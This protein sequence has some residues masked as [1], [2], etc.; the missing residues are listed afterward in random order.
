MDNRLN[1]LVSL[2]VPVFNVAPYLER[3][4]E[5]ICHQTHKDIE[6]ILVDDGSNDGSSE[7]CDHMARRDNRIR[8]IHQVN[9]GLSA[10]RNVG[11]EYAT[12]EFLSFVDSDDWILPHFV[13]TMLDI[14]TTSGCKLVMCENQRVKGKELFVSNKGTYKIFTQDEVIPRFLKGEWVSAWGKLYQRSLFDGIRFPIGRNNEDYAILIYIFEQCPQ[15]AYTADPLYC[16]IIRY[17]SITN[18]SLNEHSFDEYLNGQ[19]VWAYCL[20]RFPK[21][22]SLALFNLTASIIK[23]TGLCVLNAVFLN[24]YDDMRNFVFKYRKQ[25]L[26]NSKLSM[27]YRPFLWALMIGKPFNR[28]V[29]RAYYK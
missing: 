28:I 20:K 11:I 12:G 6:I 2:I 4:V 22:E 17:G 15:I 27:K 29:M 14:A 26:H 19:E 25:I 16:Y 23:L 1:N 8:V 21:W 10:A 3:C 9:A 5:S 18:S 24:Q 7:I 13:E